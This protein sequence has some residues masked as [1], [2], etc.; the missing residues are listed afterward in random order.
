VPLG[1]RMLKIAPESKKPLP[2]DHQAAV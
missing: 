1:R 2:E